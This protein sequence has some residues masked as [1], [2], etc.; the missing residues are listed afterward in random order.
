MAG[1]PSSPH[2]SAGRITAAVYVAG[3]KDDNSFTAGQAGLLERALTDA[4]V[5][6]TLEFYPA[7]HGFAVPDNPTYDA[8]AEARHWAALR[9]LYGASLQRP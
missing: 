3:A 8:Q 4:G 5:D 6:Y 1:D 7:R 2:L 9:E